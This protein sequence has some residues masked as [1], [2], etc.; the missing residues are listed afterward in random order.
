ML[1]W[2][3]LAP[4]LRRALVRAGLAP[5]IGLGWLAGF[6]VKLARYARAAIREGYIE[7]GKMK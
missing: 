5:F 7:G 3:R 2:S 6:I 4:L 1:R